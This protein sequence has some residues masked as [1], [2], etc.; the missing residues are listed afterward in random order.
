LPGQNGVHYRQPR[1]T[2]DVIDYVMDLQIHLRQ[3]LMYVQHVLAGHL[4]Q[5][6]AVAHDRAH[7]GDIHLRPKPSAQ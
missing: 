6:M 5:F 1:Q 7:S 3:R 4:Y 2:G